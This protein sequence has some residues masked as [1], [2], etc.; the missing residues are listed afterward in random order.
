[1]AKPPRGDCVPPI[2]ITH[3]VPSDTIRLTV[4]NRNEKLLRYASHRP[5]ELI[6]HRAYRNTL[7]LVLRF[8][9][10]ENIRRRCVLVRPFLCDAVPPANR[11]FCPTRG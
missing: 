4:A 9:Y 2:P 8:R 3:L 10:R 5:K 1:M 6:G 7:A 11:T